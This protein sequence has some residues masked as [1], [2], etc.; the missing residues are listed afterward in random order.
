MKRL[1]PVTERDLKK[2][3]RLFIDIIWRF[4]MPG[5]NGKS[6]FGIVKES[7]LLP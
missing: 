7:N 6:P 2:R 3:Y 4:V 1:L 5:L